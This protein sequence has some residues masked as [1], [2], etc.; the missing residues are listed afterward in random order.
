MG[1]AL[2]AL[3]LIR[4]HREWGTELRLR[5]Q[6]WRCAL[7]KKGWPRP[8]GDGPVLPLLIG[9][10]ADALSVQQTLET[11]GLLTVAIRPPTV[12]EGSARLRLVVRRDLPDDTLNTLLSALAS[13]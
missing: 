13:G 8:K 3:D 12:P 7:N 5:A 1:A 10:D 4:S 6:Q 2:K 9:S 11:S